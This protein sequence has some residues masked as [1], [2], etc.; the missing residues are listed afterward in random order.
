[1]NDIN[2][3]ETKRVAP[4]LDIRRGAVRLP[5]EIRET[6][7]RY[8]AALYHTI[9]SSETNTVPTAESMGKQMTARRRSA[10]LPWA[11]A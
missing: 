4:R 11:P 1:M 6:R 10:Q 3:C 9:S 8:P 2:V 5:I 7:L